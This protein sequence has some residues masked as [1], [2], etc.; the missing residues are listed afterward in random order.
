M[1]HALRFSKGLYSRPIACATP[2][3]EKASLMVE[4]PHKFAKVFSLKS[5]PLY[6]YI[7][8]WTLVFQ[9]FTHTKIWGLTTPTL[10]DHTHQIDRYGKQCNCYVCSPSFMP[11]E[12]IATERGGSIEPPKPPWLRACLQFKAPTKNTV[13][14]LELHKLKTFVK[15]KGHHSL[16]ANFLR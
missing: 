10:I 16:N 13:V 11:C 1:L 6:V 2:Q 5:F 15:T 12:Y 8:L 14:N 7:I 3:A 9:D 4:S